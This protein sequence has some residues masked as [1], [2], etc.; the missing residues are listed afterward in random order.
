M[1]SKGL[2]S[3]FFDEIKKM[4]ICHEFIKKRDTSWVCSTFDRIVTFFLSVP[5]FVR[6]NLNFGFFRNEIEYHSVGAIRQRNLIGK[7]TVWKLW[8]E[9]VQVFTIVHCPSSI[10]DSIEVYLTLFKKRFGK[11]KKWPEL[12]MLLSKMSELINIYRFIGPT[13]FR[14]GQSLLYF[15]IA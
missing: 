15:A 13:L 14:C 12:P 3:Q 2:T 11:G 4:G 10:D 6:W 1:R 7:Q 8:I 9:A 5:R